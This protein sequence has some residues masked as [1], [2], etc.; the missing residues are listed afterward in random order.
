MAIAGAV[1]LLVATARGDE[2]ARTPDATVEFSG[3]SVA[4]GVGYRWGSGT[5]TFREKKYPFSVSGLSA[6]ISAGATKVTASGSV[7]NLANLQDFDGHFTVVAAGGTLVG[8]GTAVALRNQ[9]GVLIEGVSSSEGLK[10][11]FD[12]GGVEIKVQK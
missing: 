6:G 2:P 9:K 8:G 10:I 7:Y 11:T 3:G 12:T 4:V 1:A 5:L